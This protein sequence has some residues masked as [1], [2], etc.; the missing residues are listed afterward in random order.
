MNK[1][2]IIKNVILVLALLLFTTI[3]L[4]QFNDFEGIISEIKNINLSK[5]IIVLL[6]LFLYWGTWGLSLNIIIRQKES[7]LSKSNLFLIS[8]TDLFFNGIT[9]FSSGGQPFQ[10]YAFSRGGCKASDA[11]SSL[12]MNFIIHQLAINILC[13]FSLFYYQ[14]VAKEVDMFMLFIIIG[15][16]INFLVLFLC[17]TAAIPKIKNLYFKLFDILCKVKFLNK[18]LYNKKEGFISYVDDFQLSFNELCKKKSVLFKALLVR[19]ICMLS[20]YSIPYLILIS[21][22]V[23]L[24]VDVF[25]YSL[26][27]SAFN[28]SIMS[29]VP[30]PGA[31][32]GAEL[33]LQTLLL[34]IVGV[35]ASLAI[36]T[37]VIWRFLTYYL[38]MFY[39]FIMYLIF[40]KKV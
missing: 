24:G 13:L 6:I 15:F 32:I 22:N 26:A 29:Y 8:N 36:T 5:F 18:L 1:K 17:I 16:A 20:Y 12:L 40:E 28:F 30:I 7:E 3:I 35:N 14:E 33:G 27:I 25:F 21:L 38:T 10:L 19:I 34:T 39:G 4:L 9:P 2:Q 23:N 11:T 37:I 31:S